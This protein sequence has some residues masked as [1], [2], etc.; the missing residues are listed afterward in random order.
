MLSKLFFCLLATLPLC[1]ANP[2]VI[3]T[4]APSKFVVQK[5]AE[6]TVDVEPF[7]PAGASPHSYEPTPRQLIDAASGIIWFRIGEGFEG[8]AI[9]VIKRRCKIVNLRDGLPLLKEK[10]CSCCHHDPYDP[11][12]WLS[13]PL[14]KIQAKNIK[15]VLAEVFPEHA[16]LYEKNLQAFLSELDQ[17]DDQIRT[18]IQNSKRRYILVTH[19]AFAYFCRDYGITQLSIEIDGKEPTAKQMTELLELARKEKIDRIF[20]EPQHNTKGGFRIAEEL[21]VP[22]VWLDP[23]KENVLENLKTIANAFTE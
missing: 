15:N 7:V 22:V 5:I 17:A 9:D 10:G 14:L 4:V 23:Y 16:A 3:V 1:A 21:G 12:I 2:K 11:H 18:V 8:R 20:L 13:I 19:P 6:N